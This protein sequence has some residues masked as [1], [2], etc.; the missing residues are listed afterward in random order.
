MG[1]SEKSDLPSLQAYSRDQDDA[2]LHLVEKDLERAEKPEQRAL[3][4][5]KKGNFYFRKGD[6]LSALEAYRESLS[7]TGDP[8]L[9]E[10]ITSYYSAM[11]NMGD[12]YFRLGLQ[13][14]A[15]NY[16]QSATMLRVRLTPG[17]EANRLLSLYMYDPQGVEEA[18]L[19]RLRTLVREAKRPLLQIRLAYLLLRMSRPGESLQ[20]LQEVKNVPEDYTL[21]AEAYGL[22][23]FLRLKDEKAARRS[24]A[25]IIGEINDFSGE[26][27]PWG[28]FPLLTALDFALHYGDGE[29]VQT[30]AARVRKTDFTHEETKVYRDT[31]LAHLQERSAPA[32]ATKFPG[33]G[34]SGAGH[35]PFVST[36]EKSRPCG[37]PH[38]SD[39]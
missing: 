39:R 32:G 38:F 4:L 20:V 12:I 8:P 30:L 33:S 23:N 27:P 7:I 9:P 5:V 19:T 29:M 22:Y 13:E 24:F 2:F 6:Y 25:K 16:T 31:L 26:P 18:Q 36:I 1:K 28:E 14:L 35:H 17:E 15:V 21:I 10:M 34:G 3:L 37:G 11:M